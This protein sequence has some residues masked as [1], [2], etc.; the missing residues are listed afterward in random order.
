MTNELTGSAIEVREV[1]LPGIGKKYVM[2]LRAGGNLAI[3]VRPDGERQM[4][5]FREQEDR[6]CDVVKVDKEEAQQV[7]N[8]LGQPLVGAP[9]LER[10]KLVLGGLEIEWIELGVDSTL[11]GTTVGA[12][13]LRTKTGVSIVAIMRGEQAIPNPR[14]DTVFEAGDT[15]LIIGSNPEIEAARD[16]V[17]SRA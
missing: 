8:L 3:V 9:D 16:A 15:I 7:A 6:P 17:R 14:V 12:S 11:I 1:T 4:Y 13:A 10:L 5:H 2:P